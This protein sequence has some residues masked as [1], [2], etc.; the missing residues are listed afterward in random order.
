MITRILIGIWVSFGGFMMVWKTQ[1][2]L[3][4]IGRIEWAEKNL[5]GGGSRLLYKLIGIV[6]ILIGFLAITNLYDMVIGGFI[7]SLF[8]APGA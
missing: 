3:D 5:G 7:T 4:M 1:F 6:I 2:F 8:G